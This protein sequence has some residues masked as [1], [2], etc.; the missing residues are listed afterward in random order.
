[1]ANLKAYE[2]QHQGSDIT[3]AKERL[4]YD[5]DLR[6]FVLPASVLRFLGVTQVRLLTNNPQS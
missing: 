5:P 3:E 6:D 1:M 4:G 2:L